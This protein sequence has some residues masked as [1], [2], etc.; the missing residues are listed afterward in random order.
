MM[1]MIPRSFVETEAAA[2]LVEPGNR[3]LVGMYN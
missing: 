1:R 3:E 2:M